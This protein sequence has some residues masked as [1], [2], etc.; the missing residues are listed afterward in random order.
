MT[1]VVRKLEEV[2]RS[3]QPASSAAPA[4]NGTTKK[5]VAGRTS[6]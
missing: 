3:L 5:A 1:W 4:T 6:R 2:V